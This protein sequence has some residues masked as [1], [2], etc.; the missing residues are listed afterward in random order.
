MVSFSDMRRILRWTRNTNSKVMVRFIDVPY[1]LAI[2]KLI[3][4]QDERGRDV[5]WMR[6]F[7]PKQPHQVLSSYR[8]KEIVIIKEDG[9]LEKVDDLKEIL[10]R[11]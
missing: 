7:G 3:H 4:A 1:V 8:V 10:T 5:P 6:A 11:V 9:S 2:D